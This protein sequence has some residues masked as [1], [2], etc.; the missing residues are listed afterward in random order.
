MRFSLQDVKK[1][2]HRRAGELYVS[3]HFLHPGELRSEIERLITY[4]EQLLGQPQRLFSLDDASAYIADYRLAHC[5]ISTLS[6][7][8][9][10]QQRDWR[11]AL[12]R[13]EDKAY[14]K[15]KEDGIMSP[16]HLRLAL[17]D[18]A[19]ERYHGFLDAGMRAEA[20]RQFA[21]PHQLSVSVLEYLLALDS[22]DEKILVRSSSRP[23]PAQDVATL[24]NQ[25]AFEAA[26]FNASSVHFVIDCE[27]F[28][29]TAAMKTASIASRTIGTGIGAAIKRLCYLARRLGVYYD[30]AYDKEWDHSRP[31]ANTSARYIHLM[32]YGPQEVTGAPQQYG[33]RLV[34]LCRMLLDYGITQRQPGKQAHRHSEQKQAGRGNAT[35][36]SAD[37][38]VEV[39]AI[40]HF[41][42]RSY[43]FAIDRDVLSLLPALSET[44][45]AAANGQAEVAREERG[46]GQALPLPYD[47]CTGRSVYGRGNP[48]G[49]PGTSTIFDSSIEQ[50]FAEMFA[51]LEKNSAVDGWM[52]VREPEPLLLGQGVFIPDFAFTRDH[53]RIY[54]EILGFWTPAYRER[55]IQ[56]LQQLQGR[57][58]IMLAIPLEA[59]EAFNEISTKFPVV[60]YEGQ[61]SAIDLL[62]LLRSHYDD[63]AER[64]AAI[65]IEAVRRRVESEGLLPESLCYELLHCY[66]RS[67]LVQAAE[68]VSEKRIEFTPG[69]GLYQAEWMEQLRVSFLEWLG[70]ARRLPLVDVLR[71][72]RERWPVLAA[73]ADACI[74]AILGLWPEVRIKRSSIFDA[75]VEYAG[76]GTEEQNTGT[77]PVPGTTGSKYGAESAPARKTVREKRTAQKKRV[78]REE[79]QGLL[80]DEG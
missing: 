59:K 35:R 33:I 27:A 28:E 1:Q 7:W 20:L 48:G 15:L 13:M 79:S 43:R 63:F 58:D 74:E 25:W 10:W 49:C 46:Q 30:L 6:A 32:L 51:A 66:R 16:M 76:A 47:A 37:A 36:I 80:W 61:L 5:L 24:Y 44:N 75:V 78:V 71:E 77:E 57:D 53:R 9:T 12:D 4:H 42:Q 29:Q 52:L 14:E 38:I 64:L 55:K 26:L 54:V 34:Q 2:V 73:C 40:V 3:L 8:Y 50:S 62:N 41:L 69:I 67:E 70:S 31:H 68:L 18:Y 22:D 60:W 17:F 23:P 72:S 56:K 65:D 39:E 21:E 11:E 19:N 45:Q